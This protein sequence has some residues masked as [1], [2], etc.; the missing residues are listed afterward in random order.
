VD[1]A[2][3]DSL[4]TLTGHTKLVSGVALSPDGRLLATA[5][6]DKTAAVELTWARWFRIPADGRAKA[7]LFLRSGATPVLPRRLGAVRGCKKE[8]GA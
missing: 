3:G 8:D 2:T 1:P 7:T 4:H 6:Y 5:S